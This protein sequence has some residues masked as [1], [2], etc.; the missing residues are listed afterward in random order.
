[1]AKKTPKVEDAPEP[2]SAPAQEPADRPKRTPITYT[3][4]GEQRSDG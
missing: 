4:Q 1:M 2:K 3:E